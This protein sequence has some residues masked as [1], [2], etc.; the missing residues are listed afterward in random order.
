MFK[1]KWV[2]FGVAVAFAIAAIYSLSKSKP[3]FEE[4]VKEDRE[5]YLSDLIEM[6]DSPVSGLSEFH[7]F[8]YFDPKSSWVI[9]A[10]FQADPSGES[11]PVYMTDGST[12]ELP[13]AGKATFEIDGTNYTVLIFD[14][15]ET[16]LF[17][18]TDATNDKETYGG[19]RYINLEKTSNN[20]LTIDF[21]K[22]HNFYCAYN[23]RFVCPVPPKENALPVRVEA[24]EK[25][26]K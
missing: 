20:R 12:E 18:F 1:S 10:D 24:G 16:Y 3:N 13:M 17:P 11:F 7:E 8:Y 23:E 5:K 26:L 25:R 19:G 4:A 6:E 22:A 21:N 15:G 9:Q 2:K 14:E